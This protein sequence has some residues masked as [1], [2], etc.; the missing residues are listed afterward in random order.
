MVFVFCS[1]VSKTVFLLRC[2]PW[3]GF[4][5]GAKGENVGSGRERGAH[6]TLELLQNPVHSTGAAAAA[7]DNVKVVL[8]LLSG[9]DV[10]SGGGSNVGHF[11]FVFRFVQRCEELGVLVR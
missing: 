1:L 8:V 4:D 9:G 7:H 3:P 6:F 10:G 5:G 11:C 2:W